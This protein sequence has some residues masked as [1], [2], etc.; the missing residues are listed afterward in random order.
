M[1]RAIDLRIRPAEGA[2]RRLELQTYTYDESSYA[3]MGETVYLN[4]DLSGCYISADLTPDEARVLA[5]QLVQVAEVAEAQRAERLQRENY[6]TTIEQMRDQEDDLVR[7]AEARGEEYVPSAISSEHM[8]A[9]EIALEHGAPLL[10][11]QTDLV[12]DDPRLARCKVIPRVAPAQ[13][14]A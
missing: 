14:S 4:L 6:E 7:E 13:V 10:W 1:T 3:H 12:R 11:W 9:I 2:E 8:N 5:G